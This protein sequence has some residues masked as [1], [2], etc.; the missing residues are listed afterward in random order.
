MINMAMYEELSKAKIS[1]DAAVVS[2][3]GVNVAKERLKN[4]LFNYYKDL[5]AL[6]EENKKLVEENESLNIALQEADEDLNKAEAELKKLR[7]KKKSVSPNTE[8]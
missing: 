1:Y 7:P 4:L 6:A 2:R 8:E 5:V 3:S